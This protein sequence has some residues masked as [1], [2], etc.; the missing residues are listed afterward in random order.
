MSV[1]PAGTAEE[2][3]TAQRPLMTDAMPP[4]MGVLLWHEIEDLHSSVIGKRSKE[5]LPNRSRGMSDR[6]CCAFQPSRIKHLGCRIEIEPGN[7]CG[8]I[9]VSEPMHRTRCGTELHHMSPIGGEM[10]I[11]P[12]DGLVCSVSDQP[13]ETQPFEHPSEADL[14]GKNFEFAGGGAPQSDI[15]NAGQP[16]TDHIDDLSIEDIAAKQQLISFEVRAHRV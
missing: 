9:T 1:M 6:A 16:V 3:S 14:G 15:S 5:T 13:S 4:S 11:R 7:Q 2:P 12:C 10:E 8:K